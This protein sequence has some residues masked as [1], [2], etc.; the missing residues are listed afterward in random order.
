MLELEERSSTHLGA[1]QRL[2]SSAL[3]TECSA[4]IGFCSSNE[5]TEHPISMKIN[6]GK[7]II[8]SDQDDKKIDSYDSICQK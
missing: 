5:V 7:I 2:I 1:R 3:L 8:I 6:I 4:K